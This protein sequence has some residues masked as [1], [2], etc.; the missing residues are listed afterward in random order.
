L[1]APRAITRLAIKPRE[2]VAVFHRSIGGLIEV[3]S[4]YKK[5]QLKRTPVMAQ[6]LGLTDGTKKAAKGIKAV[7]TSSTTPR[8]TRK[9]TDIN[10]RKSKALKRNPLKILMFLIEVS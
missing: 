1:R 2:T 3:T 5:T 6:E 9:R 4:E 7:I 8:L 10:A